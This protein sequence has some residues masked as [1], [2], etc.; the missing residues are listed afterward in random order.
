MKTKCNGKFRFSKPTNQKIPSRNL[1]QSN[2]ENIANIISNIWP[3]IKRTMCAKNRVK[4]SVLNFILTFTYSCQNSSFQI[5]FIG[6]NAKPI[7]AA[8]SRHKYF[9]FFEIC[10]QHIMGYIL[11][12]IRNF[13]SSQSP[14]ISRYYHFQ[15]T[16]SF[17]RTYTIV[18][19]IL[20][21]RP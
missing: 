12:M 3:I 9:I 8:N 2:N 17:W 15:K 14:R 13:Q 19:A 5:Y 4:F 16:P 1:C 20:F 11:S 21:Q 7:T 18:Y 10:F 6:L